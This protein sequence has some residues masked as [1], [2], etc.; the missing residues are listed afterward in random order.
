M[1]SDT[2]F[3]WNILSLVYEF[4]LCMCANLCMN[5]E[6]QRRADEE[7]AA[8]NRRIPGDRDERRG[9]AKRADGEGRV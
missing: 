8:R 4:Y 1:F 5:R 2:Y 3:C 7:G 9:D 6:E